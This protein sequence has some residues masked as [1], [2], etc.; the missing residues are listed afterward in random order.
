MYEK[1]GTVLKER[2]LFYVGIDII[3]KHLIEINV[4]STGSIDKFNAVYGK[5][6]EKM[7]WDSFVA[8]Q[9][10]RDRHPLLR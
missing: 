5:K 3:G 7:F 1:I 10:N 9:M 6:L 2:E 8:T 4:T